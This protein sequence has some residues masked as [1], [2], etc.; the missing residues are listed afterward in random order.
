MSATFPEQVVAFQLKPQDRMLRRAQGGQDSQGVAVV[1]GAANGIKRV[2]GL[3]KAAR[4]WLTGGKG[5][6][7][8]MRI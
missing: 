6:T 8:G 2:K 1:H 3:P 4:R 5:L 7:P